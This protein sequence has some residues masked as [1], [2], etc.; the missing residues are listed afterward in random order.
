M[1]FANRQIDRALRDAPIIRTSDHP[2]IVL[3]SDCHRGIGTAADSFL[4]NKSFYMAALSY[5]YNAG[6]TYIELGDGDELWENRRWRDICSGAITTG[7]NLPAAFSPHL[8][9]VFPS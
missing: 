4:P 6:F 9:S 8:Q 2:K 7:Q 1:N 5:Y 3:F